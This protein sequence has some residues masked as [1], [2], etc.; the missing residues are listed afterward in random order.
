MTF[1]DQ[2]KPKIGLVL[3]GGGAKG[4]YQIGCW[5]AL[6]KAGLT[7]LGALAGTSVGAMNAT[8]I[9]ANK[10]EDAEA[11]WKGLGWRGVVGIQPRKVLLFPFWILAAV[12]SEFSL[13]KMLGISGS[14]IIPK[15]KFLLGVIVPNR[16]GNWPLWTMVGVAAW[17]IL[18][19]LDEMARRV[20]LGW[21]FTT[22]QPLGERLYS[23]LSDAD[24]ETMKRA[25]VPV[26]AALSRYR[27]GAGW[28]P[29]YV[30][31]DKL[32]RKGVVDTL[33]R[34]AAIPGIFP[35]RRAA[36]RHSVDGGCTDNI[37][38]APL[39]FDSE[40][41]VNLVFVIKVNKG[42]RQA[43]KFRHFFASVSKKLLGRSRVRKESDQEELI[44]WSRAK[45]EAH[46]RRHPPSRP[47]KRPGPEPVLSD[48][49]FPDAKSESPRSFPR[50]VSVVPSKPIGS[51]PFGT[52]W[53]SKA[54]AGKL[55]ELGEK[56]MEAALAKLKSEFT[57]T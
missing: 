23:I 19:V 22:N 4:A 42:A 52:F 53:F 16:G 41:Q 21:L 9:A 44:Q 34:S 38:A 30:R 35:V 3:T 26:Y 24:I 47:R 2:R 55:I 32:N 43:G 14:L 36:G 51:F 56:D 39:L 7:D 28:V 13:A 46:G 5:K 18:G 37:P 57:P 10:L 48:R 6:R 27:P 33:L 50:I 8:L 25:Q 17:G 54:K 45:W 12:F 15:R 49:G 1:P 11:A 40:V 29:R 20:F 31:L